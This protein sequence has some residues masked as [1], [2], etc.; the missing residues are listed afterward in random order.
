VF[1][2]T[3]THTHKLRKRQR[4]KGV[5]SRRINFDR[6]DRC[7]SAPLSR[8]AHPNLR[9]PYLLARRRGPRRVRVVV[10]RPQ[11]RHEVAE[12]AHEGLPLG[13]RRQLLRGPSGRRRQALLL[14]DG[15]CRAVDGEPDGRLRYGAHY[16]K[17]GGIP[18]AT[19]VGRV[20]TID[21]REA[22]TGWLAREHD[23][24]DTGASLAKRSGQGL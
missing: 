13:A 19:E 14:G 11:E 21:R 5:Q 16:L 24:S 9:T 17:A 3:L 22:C 8:V 15:R 7:V 20:G 6:Q 18:V 23:T 4:K 10:V 1:A 12:Q 2:Q